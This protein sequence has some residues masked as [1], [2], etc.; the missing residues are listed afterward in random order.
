[1][2]PHVIMVLKCFIVLLISIPLPDAA[3]L[4]ALYYC[5]PLHKA[6]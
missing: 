1:M 5:V 6:V 3:I 4:G 2:N